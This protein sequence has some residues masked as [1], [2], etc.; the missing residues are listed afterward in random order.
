ME[1]LLHWMYNGRMWAE[2]IC[3]PCSHKR[4]IISG[5]QMVNSPFPSQ[6]SSP[7]NQITVNQARLIALQASLVQCNFAD[8]PQT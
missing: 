5:P 4:Q 7:S 1:Q 6:P 8:I 3:P 2:L